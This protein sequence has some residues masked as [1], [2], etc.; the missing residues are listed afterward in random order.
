MQLP[1]L[2]IRAEPGGHFGHS[3][4][5]IGKLF[6]NRSIANFPKPLSCPSKVSSQAPPPRQPRNSATATSAVD[7]ISPGSAL[8][9]GSCR[10]ALRIR[11][12][13]HSAPAEL[14]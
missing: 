3:G 12:K 6:Y 8:G 2:V 7:P 13:R 11:G 5:Q 9:G 4:R 14:D 1:I 10:V